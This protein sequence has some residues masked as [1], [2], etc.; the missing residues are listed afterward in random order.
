MFRN[1]PGQT[2]ADGDG[3]LVDVTDVDVD[4]AGRYIISGFNPDD[5]ENIG[6]S[7][8]IWRIQVGVRYEF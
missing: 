5:G 2:F 3:P 1:I 6:V 8:S 4:A 7:S